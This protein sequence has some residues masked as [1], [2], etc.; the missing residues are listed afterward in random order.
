M[1]VKK[2]TALVAITKH[3]TELAKRLKAAMPE[4]ELLVSEKFASAAPG[5]TVMKETVSKEIQRW[6]HDYEEICFV[7]SLGAVVRMIAP[8]LKDKHSDPGV[9]C[10]D[11][12]G[13]FAI[14]VL[15]GHVGGANAFCEKVAKALGAQAVVTTASDVGKTLPVDILG[16]ELGWTPEGEENVTRVSASVVNEEPVAFVQECGEKTWWTR[17]VP[18][19]KSIT[20]LSSLEGVDLS[21]FKSF[22]V[23]TDRLRERLP[24]VIQ[25]RLVLYRPK[26]IVLG[27]GCDRGVPEAAMFEAVET[28]LKEAGL[29][30]RCVRNVA[31]ID[32][33]G[34]EPAILS[35]CERR[36]WPLV[37]F[38]RD[39]LNETFA[40]V[41]VPNP[42]AV[43][44]KYTGTP[45]VS[46]PS[47]LRSTGAKTLLQE[48][49]KF[50]P[51]ITVAVARVVFP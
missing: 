40:K 50:P 20:V 42:S 14:S 21:A 46:E 5:A 19:P 33:K 10:V 4:A 26:S 23:V 35:L 3:G 18:L 49:R 39:E 7:I 41:A 27:L 47:A 34:N 17:D 11:D 48:K 44:K 28:T 31:T 29:S 12:R 24:D 13:Q 1:S 2:P 15:S 38:T 51:G 45:G 30:L 25:D 37:T 22:L 43:V 8:V 32:I 36:N 16:R 6:F 9:V